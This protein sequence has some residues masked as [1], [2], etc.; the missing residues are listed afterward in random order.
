MKRILFFISLLFIASVCLDAQTH[1]KS[2]VHIGG[3][4]G[5]TL[6]EM[7]FVPTTKQTMLAGMTMGFSFRY[8]EERHVGLL[9]ELNFSQRGWKED[10]EGAP[11]SYSR[12][13]TYI[14]LPVMTHIFFGSRKFKGF[15]NL[16]PQI[17]LNLGSSISSNFDYE[18]PESVPEMPQGYRMNDQM[19]M[20]VKNKF[21]YGICAGLGGEYIMRHRHSFMLEARFYYGLG[22]LFAD[23]KKDTFSAS[24]SLSFYITLGYMFRI[25]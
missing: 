23:S 22:N 16:G 14:E 10:F 5:F 24:R 6:S 11:L 20:S 1:Y 19:W 15:V 7:D 12:T 3:H 21:D 18:H 8:A 13:L 4:A 25:K 17:G 9:A 2:H